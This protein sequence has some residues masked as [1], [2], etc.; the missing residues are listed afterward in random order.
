[1]SQHSTSRQRASWWRWHLAHGEN[2]SATARHFGIARST[3]YRWQRR[4]GRPALQAKVWFRRLAS[5]GPTK[6]RPVERRGRPRRFW[7][8]FYLGLVSDLDLQHPRWGRR[9]VHAALVEG[10]FPIS[11]ATVGRLLGEVRRRCPICRGQGR[12]HDLA[13]LA[14][15]DARM[16]HARG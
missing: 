12:H 10:G 4:R 14:S 3:F 6:A 2:V 1:M 5:G 13:H 7:S 11:E 16:M 9:R 8:D 15:H